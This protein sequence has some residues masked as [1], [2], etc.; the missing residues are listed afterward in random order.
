MQYRSLR[1]AIVFVVSVLIYNANVTAQQQI[2][3]VTTAVP[4]LRVSPDA[5]SG[6]MGDVGIAIAPD[7]NSNF[8]NAAKTTFNKNIGGVGVTYTPWLKDVGVNDVYYLTMGGFYQLDDRQALHGGIRYFNLGD[9][10]FTD[11]SG[12]ITGYGSPKE[13]SF[14]AGYS[15]KLSKTLALGITGRYII[16]SLVNGGVSNNGTV[17]KAGHAVAADVSLYQNNTDD[18]GEGLS[19]GLTLSNLGTK[20]GYTNDASNKDFIPANMGIGIAYTKVYDESNK[21][22]FALDINKLL[23]P[24]APLSQDNG[25]PIDSA[26]LASYRSS[27]VLSSWFKSFSDGTNQ[28]KDLQFSVGAEYSYE[29][30]FMLRAGYYYED[31]IRGDRKYFSV[32]AGFNYDIYGINLSYIVPSG[33][34]ITRNP[35]SNTLR[36]GVTFNFSK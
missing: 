13:Y 4:F 9:M 11:Y 30:M 8:W 19:W 20:I 24:M 5:R 28:L 1:K 16:S 6:G 33:N 25:G 15:I 34:G 14:D 3:V 31:A 17:Y 22:T 29:D 21:L 35:L 36:L 10:Q 27:S 18:K 2:N 32:G 12:N 23:V 26:A 7:A